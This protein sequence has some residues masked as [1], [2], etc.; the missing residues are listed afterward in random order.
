MASDGFLDGCGNFIVYLICINGNILHFEIHYEVKLSEL[1]PRVEGFAAIKNCEHE[2]W[3]SDVHWNQFLLHQ[4]LIERL[5]W[6]L[7]VHTLSIGVVKGL[8]AASDCIV[9]TNAGK[10][11]PLCLL[12]IFFILFVYFHGLTMDPMLLIYPIS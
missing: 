11:E 7:G 8:Q 1:D 12:K 9:V 4:I 5:A 2:L 6:H 10:I 3:H